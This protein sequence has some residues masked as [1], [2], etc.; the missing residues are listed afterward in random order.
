MTK[1]SFNS[2]SINKIF[3]DFAKKEHKVN[4][5]NLKNI[6]KYILFSISKIVYY[7]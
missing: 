3:L 4:N 7:N 6:T 2:K 5:K 1:A